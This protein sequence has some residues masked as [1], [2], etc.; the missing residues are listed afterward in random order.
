M[1]EKDFILQIKHLCSENNLLLIFDEV[2]CGV[3]RTGKLYAFEHYNVMPDIL[4]TAKGLAAGIPIGACICTNEI[5]QCMTIGSHGSTFGGNPFAMSLVNYVLD[6]VSKPEFLQ[7]ISI[8]SDK[9]KTS[10]EKIIEKTGD[11]ITE[12]RGKGLLLGVKLNTKYTTQELVL[13]ARKN[14]LL[15]APTSYDNVIR[16]LPRLNA[17]DGEISDFEEKLYTSIIDL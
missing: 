4:I 10:V 5:A 3:G 8:I 2:Q 13:S 1:C 15:L 6:T 14:K 11:K 9:I 16:L 17:T 12:I 7:N